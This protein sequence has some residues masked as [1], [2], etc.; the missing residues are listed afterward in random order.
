MDPKYSFG[1]KLLVAGVA[2]CAAAYFGMDI[3][4]WVTT[5]LGTTSL[6]PVTP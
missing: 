4:S 5:M 2:V 6:P 3:A 1:I